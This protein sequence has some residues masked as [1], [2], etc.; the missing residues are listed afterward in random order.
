MV[1]RNVISITFSC[2]SFAFVFI[3]YCNTTV[4]SKRRVELK[5]LN[6]SN[7]FLYYAVF[8]VENYLFDQLSKNIGNGCKIV[9]KTEAV[10]TKCIQNLLVEDK[11]A[12]PWQKQTNKKHEGTTKEAK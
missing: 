5:C 12:T 3:L 9:L 10:E 7:F 4:P 11:L 1:C 8:R 2:R 6:P